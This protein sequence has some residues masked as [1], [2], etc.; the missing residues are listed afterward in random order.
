MDTAIASFRVQR[1]F[2]ADFADLSRRLRP[3]ARELPI[4]LPRL[5]AAFRVGTP[6]VRRSVILNNNTIKVFNGL[7]D[8]VKDPNTLLGLKDLSTLTRVTA[9]LVTYIAPYQTVCDYGTIFFN[10]LGSHIS[11]GTA[12]GT[13]ERVLVTLG[14]TQQN[15]GPGNFAARPSD[16][17]PNVDPTGAKTTGPSPKAIY[18][19]HGPAY[20]PAIDAQGNADCAKGQTGYPDGPLID[21]PGRYPPVNGTRDPD[22]SFNTWQAAHGGGGHLVI[23]NDAPFSYGPNYSGLKRLQDVDKQLKSDGVNP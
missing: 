23:A 5:N 7:N 6:V 10:G 22:G 20:T 14:D 18:V 12:N 13:A 1:P 19:L 4:A 17:P 8:L 15:D 3:A 21:G 11:E 2:L 16:L 9:P